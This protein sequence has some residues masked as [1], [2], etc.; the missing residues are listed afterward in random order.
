MVYD[1]PE[2]VR[3]GLQEARKASLRRGDRLCVHD[4]R[5]V[6]RINRF[7]VD[8]FS[9]DSVHA[10]KLRGRVE[11]YDG[12][13]HLYQCLIVNSSEEADETV[14]DFKWMHPVRTHPAV[15]FVQDRQAP[16]GLLSHLC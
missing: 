9:I 16:A 11:I 12:A 4:G 7:W 3:L 6:Y 2:D 5:N 13:R 1:L 15:D 14:F 10:A 8:G